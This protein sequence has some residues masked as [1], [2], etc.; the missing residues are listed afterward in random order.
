MNATAI[1]TIENYRSFI[2]SPKSL[3][4]IYELTT[5]VVGCGINKTLGQLLAVTRRTLGC[6]SYA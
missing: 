6:D 3:H 5:L 1:Y 4:A 2:N